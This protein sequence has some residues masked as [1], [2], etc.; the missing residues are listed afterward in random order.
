MDLSGCTLGDADF[1]G[2]RLDAAEFADTRFHGTAVFAGAAFADAAFQRAVFYG[3]AVFTGAR[4]GGDA[5][6]GRARFR[7]RADFTGAVF[8]GTA[9]FGRGADTWWDDDAAW[10][11]VEEI[12]P[13]PWEEPNEDDPNWPVAVLIEDY[14][15]WEEGGDGARFLGDA[16]FRDVRFDGP[17][18]FHYARFGAAAT[19]AGARFAGRAH[20]DQPAVDLTGAHWGGD[21]G[22]GEP[23]WPLGWTARPVAAGARDGAADLVPDASVAPYTG[24]LADPDPE[25]RSAG[26][27]IL[28]RLGDDRPEARQ[29]V[30]ATW[31]AF[32]RIP[33]RSTCARTAAHPSRT[34]CCGCGGKRSGRSPNGSGPAPV[35]GR[36]WTC[37][38]AVP[39]SSTWTSA[40][41]KPTTP[42]SPALSSTARPGSTAAASTTRSSPWTGHPAGP[43][44]T[45]TWC[46]GPTRPATSSSTAR[47][48][49]RV[50]DLDRVN[51]FA[52]W[53]VTHVT[54]I[55]ERTGIP[56]GRDGL[57]VVTAALAVAAVTVVAAPGAAVAGVPGRAAACTPQGPDFNG[58]RCGD[59]VVG[60]PGA[61]VGSA[62]GRADHRALRRGWRSGDG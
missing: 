26:L 12:D 31:C 56:V 62:R 53:P 16:S 46:S 38:S 41:A 50:T 40:A 36:A 59:V 37:G 23:V 13:A 43:A 5:E 6:F 22:D 15:D 61:A 57:A 32:L 20:L 51:R 30:V 8:S 33:S 44:S 14:Q 11:T 47:P 18:W 3:D 58:D 29:R 17:A 55:T 27:Q 35:S 39:R 60:D 34:R 52:S 45:A 28:A 25:V 54:D 7:R 49:D 9:W 42:T 19:F 2:C 21:T 10:E 24:Q 1:S 4:F 48:R